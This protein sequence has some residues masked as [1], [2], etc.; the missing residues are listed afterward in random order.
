MLSKMAP[1]AAAVTEAERFAEDSI[2][3]LYITSRQD[4]EGSGESNAK[5][6]RSL[7]FAF[8]SPKVPVEI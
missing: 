4:V 7:T 3:C 1:T 6:K 2:K 5:E 8:F